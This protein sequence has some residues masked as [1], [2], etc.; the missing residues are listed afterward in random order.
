MQAA[1]NFYI[2]SH[3]AFQ[4]ERDLYTRGGADL[5]SRMPAILG[6]DENAA[7]KHKSPS[8]YTFPAF[9]ILERGQS[10][11]EWSRKNRR[12]DFTTVLQ[13]GSPNAQNDATIVGLLTL[14][15]SLLVFQF[16]RGDRYNKQMFQRI[17][18]MQVLDLSVKALAE[19]HGVGY[20]HRDIK[21]GNILR[22]PDQN[23]WTLIDLGCAASIGVP[24]IPLL[25]ALTMHLRA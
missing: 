8:G 2:R 23:D 11:D 10:L 18:R 19:L 17:G 20:A 14:H 16:D 9:V 7:G 15:E 6:M 3:A 4:R 12:K 21:P 22:R 1:I 5:T 24:S 13:V 25:R